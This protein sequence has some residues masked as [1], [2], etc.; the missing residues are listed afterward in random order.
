MQNLPNSIKAARFFYCIL[1]PQVQSFYP[2]VVKIT[3]DV[4]RFYQ[5]YFPSVK[6]IGFQLPA[7]PTMEGSHELRHFAARSLVYSY[8]WLCLCMVI[9]PVWFCVSDNE[10]LAHVRSYHCLIHWLPEAPAL[11]CSYTRNGWIFNQ[12][13]CFIQKKKT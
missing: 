4:K 6:F 1:W 7:K 2:F 3:C 8:T 12:N 5:L 10:L 11:T 9:C 13:D